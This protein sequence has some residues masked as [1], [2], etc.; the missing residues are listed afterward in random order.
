MDAV[1]SGSMQVPDIKHSLF[2]I[3]LFALA[4][5]CFTSNGSNVDLS[6][7]TSN[8]GPFYASNFRRVECNSNNR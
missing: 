6:F 7:I 8:I 3:Y 1:D 4:L 5:Y 2:N